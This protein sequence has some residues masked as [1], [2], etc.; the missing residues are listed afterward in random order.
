MSNPGAEDLP[1]VAIVVKT[2][3]G[4][5][6]AITDS[7]RLLAAALAEEGAACDFVAW[8]D[9]GFLGIRRLRHR[10]KDLGCEIVHLQ[11]PSGTGYSFRAGLFALTTPSVVTL[12]EGI[13]YGPVRGRL[14]VLPY[15]L[16]SR[17]LFF[18]EAEQA[19]VNRWAPWTRGRSAFMRLPALV[20]VSPGETRNEGEICVFSQIRRDKGLEEVVELGRLIREQDLPWRIRVAGY[21]V[22]RDAPYF[23]HLQAMAEGLPVAWSTNLSDGEVASFLGTASIAYLPFPDGGA[24]RRSSLTATMASGTPVVTTQGRETTPEIKS[25][26]RIAGTPAEAIATIG[27]ILGDPLEWARLSDAGLVYAAGTSSREVAAASLGLYRQVT[28]GRGTGRPEKR[29]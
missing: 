17:M 4:W 26:V 12:H 22:E 18:S 10:L 20:A 9:W 19:Y 25:A 16:R 21:L 15:T 11:F 8:E 7:A 27:Q 13:H 2:K 24:E 29:L 3:P 6:S 5:K 1:R 23:A 28:S 14:K